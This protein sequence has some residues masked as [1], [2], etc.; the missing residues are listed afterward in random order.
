MRLLHITGDPAGNSPLEISLCESL[1]SE[2]PPYAILSHRWR[3]EEVVYADM[4]YTKIEMVCRIA[5]QEGFSYVWTDNCCIDKTSSAELSEAI[6]SVYRYYADSGWCIAY[7]DDTD[8]NPHDLPAF[9]PTSFYGY[10][11]P[12]IPNPLMCA[13]WFTRGWTL[14]ELIAPKDISEK[15]SWAARR[16]TIRPEDEAYS[17]MGLFGVNM[18]TLYGEGRSSAFRR[19]QLEIMQTTTDHSLFAWKPDRLLLLQRCVLRTDRI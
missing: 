11:Y 1:G 15:M 12:R 19:L 6:N 13:T 2:I 14:Q 7:L 16:T 8:C 9:W 18:G 5:L 10:T 4:G 17:L 3:V